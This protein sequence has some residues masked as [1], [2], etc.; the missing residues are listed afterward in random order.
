MF[1]DVSDFPGY[2][3]F[4]LVLRFTAGS[5]LECLLMSRIF[6]ALDLPRDSCLLLD[7]AGEMRVSTLTSSGSKFWRRTA[8]FR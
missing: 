1:V 3:V 6:K 2:Y 4:E 8:E 5:G 7:H